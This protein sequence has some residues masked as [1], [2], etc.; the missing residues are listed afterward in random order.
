[1]LYQLSYA[2]PNSLC[3]VS[4]EGVEPP[5]KHHAARLKF[6]MWAAGEQT[7]ADCAVRHGNST[8][9]PTHRHAAAMNEAQSGGRNAGLELSSNLVAHIDE[10]S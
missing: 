1:M 7:S 4:F 3:F 10:D 9:G 5:A 8:A 6:S 2:S